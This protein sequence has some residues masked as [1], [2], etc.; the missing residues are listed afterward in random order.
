ML[1][2]AIQKTL[3]DGHVQD[4]VLASEDSGLEPFPVRPRFL[5]LAGQPTSNPHWMQS[6]RSPVPMRQRGRLWRAS[7]GLQL[8]VVLAKASAATAPQLNFSLCAI[9]LPSLLCSLCSRV[10][11]P[12]HVRH[13]DLR[14]PFPGC[15]RV[16]PYLGDNREWG[17]NLVHILVFANKSWCVTQLIG[18]GGG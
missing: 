3:Q 1:W 5:P 11:S 9:L 6:Y 14:S 4:G 7:P 2:R 12:L 10:Y 13:T 18:W 15:V 16:M 8:L 17:S